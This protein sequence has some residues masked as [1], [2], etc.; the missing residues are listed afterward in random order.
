MS[1]PSPALFSSGLWLSS[2]PL[3]QSWLCNW[4]HS[5]EY[6]RISCLII[7]SF[8]SWAIYLCNDSRGPGLEACQGLLVLRPVW[9]CLS[10]DSRHIRSYI[11][12]QRILLTCLVTREQTQVCIHW[13][14][15]PNSWLYA[16]AF[17]HSIS[18]RTPGYST[19][20]KGIALWFSL[21]THLMFK[22]HPSDF[23]IF[24]PPLLS[25]TPTVT[26]DLISAGGSRTS[27]GNLLS[28][29]S[30]LIL[31]HPCSTSPWASPRTYTLSC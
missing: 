28:D 25:S 11:L 9:C 3:R 21:L 16:L 31:Q 24:P 14:M 13:L 2:S 8:W 27:R 19:L 15:V 7:L 22:C 1:P 29:H 18:F 5:F 10:L 12:L 26:G 6:A 20:T 23:S 4:T 17:S 30:N